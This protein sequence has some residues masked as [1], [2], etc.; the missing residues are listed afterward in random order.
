M[1][2]APSHATDVGTPPKWSLLPYACGTKGLHTKATQITNDRTSLVSYTTHLHFRINCFGDLP[3]ELWRIVW[4]FA[5][6]DA[7]VVYRHTLTNKEAIHNGLHVEVNSLVAGFCGGGA[8][9]CSQPASD[10]YRNVPID[11]PTHGCPGVG[12]EPT[13]DW[14]PRLPRRLKYLRIS[15]R[16]LTEAGVKLL[17]ATLTTF[18]L[19]HNKKMSPTVLRFLPRGL[20]HLILDEQIFRMFIGGAEQRAFDN[21]TD[22]DLENE[23]L[24]EKLDRQKWQMKECQSLLHLPK[25]LLSLHIELPCPMTWAHITALPRTLRHLNVGSGRCSAMAAPK[26]PPQ[27][28][29]LDVSQRTRDFHLVRSLPS[30]LKVLHFIPSYPLSLSLRYLQTWNVYTLWMTATLPTV[31]C[32]FFHHD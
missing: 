3:G 10:W 22:V 19:L 8:W 24:P 4:A 15:S 11:L 17:P 1:K 26:W 2:R 25:G 23:S 14:I 29:T 21:E 13:D 28:E 6:N 32:L 12:L 30:T 27:L 31:T 16:H 18:E 5:G 9:H 7:C 20:R